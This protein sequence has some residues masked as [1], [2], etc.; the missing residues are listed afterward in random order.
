[1]LTG[2][3]LGACVAV[4]GRGTTRAEEP[5]EDGVVARLSSLM[6]E[7]GLWVSDLGATAGSVC[8]GC[9]SVEFLSGGLGTT[10]A[11]EFR[12]GWFATRFSS[13][14]RGAGVIGPG[15]GVATAGSVCIGCV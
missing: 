10:R 9:A 5:V 14:A 1:V 11:G 12:P 2:V 8:I 15:L 4:G 3:G 13:L 7:A 6:R